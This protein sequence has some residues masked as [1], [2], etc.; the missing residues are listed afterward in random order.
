M[1]IKASIAAMG[2]LVAVAL[3]VPANFSASG[4]E[5]IRCG[6]P[7]PPTTTSSTPPDDGGPGGP[8]G[9]GGDLPT[10]PPEE[11]IRQLEE[12][13][14]GALQDLV[15]IPEKMVL[16][17]DNP[18]GV[19]V[20][21]VCNSGLGHQAKIDASQALPLQD[22]I[23]ANPVLMGVLKAHGFHAEDVV[24]VVLI[25]GVATLYVHKNA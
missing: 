4:A 17:F 25:K 9:D 13:C 2:A 19:T 22:A 1:L 8:G 5:C 3:I 23:A 11:K 20:A 14:N 6:P 12:T 24:G 7:P 10:P 16:E 21:P 18:S 15:K